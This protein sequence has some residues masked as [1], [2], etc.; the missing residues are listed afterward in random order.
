MVIKDER[1]ESWESR[2]GIGKLSE[3]MRRDVGGGRGDRYRRT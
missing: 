1:E 3:R 2:S